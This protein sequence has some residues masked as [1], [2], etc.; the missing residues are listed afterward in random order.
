MLWNTNC[1]FSYLLFHVHNFFL[2]LLSLLF[3]VLVFW[4]MVSWQGYARP[5]F[6]RASH[7][8]QRRLEQVFQQQRR[9]WHAVL[10]LA[11]STSKALALPLLAHT[12]LSSIECHS[13]YVRGRLYT[14]WRFLNRNVDSR[15][16]SL[17][18]YMHRNCS[19]C[20]MVVLDIFS[21]NEVPFRVEGYRLEQYSWPAALPFAY[22][23]EMKSLTSD[24]E[25]RKRNMVR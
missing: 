6:T 2:L 16:V 5:S 14:F 23:R 8:S 24:L 10:A 4:K 19:G 17:K 18:K 25:R 20:D 7:N 13:V 12:T 22:Q 15:P 11:P 21:P 3:K 9:Y 1:L